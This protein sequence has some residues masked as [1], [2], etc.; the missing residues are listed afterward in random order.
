M[1]TND[2]PPPPPRV[3]LTSGTWVGIAGIAVTLVIALLAAAERVRDRI[4]D[5]EIRLNGRV[6]SLAVDVAEMRGQLD[7]M[8]EQFEA[9]R[10]QFEA[11]RGQVG[12][13]REQVGVMREQ[14]GVMRGQFDVMRGQLDVM[15]GQL[16]M[17]L[18]RM[19]LDAA[20]QARE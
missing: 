11:L 16:G 13:M 18:Q 2:M 9:L 10:G 20:G 12:V 14:I 3:Q 17:L 15:R 5:L 19:G 1:T 4:D 7:V 6:D 8:R